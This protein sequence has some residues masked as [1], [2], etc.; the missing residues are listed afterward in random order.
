MDKSLKKKENGGL[1]VDTLR[2]EERNGG[3]VVKTMETTDSGQSLKPWR[4][5]IVK[6]R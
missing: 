3:Y 2:M 1:V 6:N 5:Q 4:Q